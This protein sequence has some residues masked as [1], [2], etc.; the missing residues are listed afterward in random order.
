LFKRLRERARGG[1][2]GI[3]HRKWGEKKCPEQPTGGPKVKRSGF[4]TESDA[5][6]SNR[7]IDGH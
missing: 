1:G 5:E 3:N 7:G 2:E 6:R 4:S